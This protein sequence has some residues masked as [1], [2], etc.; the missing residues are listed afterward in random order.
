MG[1]EKLNRWDFQMFAALPKQFP[2]MLGNFVFDFSGSRVR[3]KGR[4]LLK[5]PSY[6]YLIPCKEMREGMSFLSLYKSCPVLCG[7]G[8]QGSSEGWQQ[9]QKLSIV[10][11]L[12]PLAWQLQEYILYLYV[13]QMLLLCLEPS[14]SQRYYIWFCPLEAEC[15]W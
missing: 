12:H 11:E 6:T 4:L 3:S 10:K 7:P 14:A 2:L 1:W 13:Q 15:I 5:I 8:V 9:A